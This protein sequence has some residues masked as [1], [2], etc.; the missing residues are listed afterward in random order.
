MPG[1]SSHR[2]A[3][4][5]TRPSTVR[6]VARRAR[7]TALETN[8][9]NT[10]V[11]TVVWMRH[12]DLVGQ[13]H[14]EFVHPAAGGG[15]GTGTL[16]VQFNGSNVATGVTLINFAVTIADSG[17]TVTSTGAGLVRFELREADATAAP[18]P[19]GRGGLVSPLAQVFAGRKR[20]RDGAI[21]GDAALTAGGIIEFLGR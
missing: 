7:I 5:L 14:Y 18:G 21:V 4:T 9:N 3:R 12:R 6:G 20:F 8:N 17:L 19:S 10:A 11:D 2:A 1:W 13:L 16:S 15:G